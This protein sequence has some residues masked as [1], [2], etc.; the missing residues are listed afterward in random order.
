MKA[1][2]MQR[3]YCLNIRAPWTTNQRHGTIFVESRDQCGSFLVQSQTFLEQEKQWMLQQSRLYMFKVRI[4]CCCFSFFFS[5]VRVLVSRLQDM[6]HQ[7]RGVVCIPSSE[8]NPQWLEHNTFCFLNFTSELLFPFIEKRFHYMYI[9][10]KW[11]LHYKIPW[12]QRLSCILYW[13]ILRRE[14][15]LLIVFIGTKR[16][17]PR[18]ESLW[19]RP[20]G[21]SL[22]CHQLLTVVFWLE[23]IFDCSA[24]HMIGWIKYLW[25]IYLYG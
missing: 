1:P 13:Q 11:H 25:G 6:E 22:S 4:I 12:S 20:L 2:F 18:K 21:T 19:S 17:E 9:F 10:I 23:D 24:S 8:I 7:W 16:W 3:V 5:S 14:P 15:L